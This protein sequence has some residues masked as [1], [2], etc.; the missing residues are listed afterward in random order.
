MRFDSKDIVKNALIATIYVLLTYMQNVLLPGTTSAA[1]QFRASEAM[2]M[3]ALF[4]PTATFG[5]T[6]GC[7]ISNIFS[8]M[9]VD[10][11][12]GSFATFLAGV[13]IYATRNIKIKDFPILSTIF[14]AVWNGLIIGLEI[15]LYYIGNFEWIS[16]WIQVAC[17]FIGELAVSVILGIP[18]YFTIKRTKNIIN[19]K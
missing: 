15:Q 13:S 16:F 9:P 5:L 1:I 7:C 8:G 10:M 17:V 18:L 6:V 3:L 4:F 2:M 12:I 11:I 14:P 19:T